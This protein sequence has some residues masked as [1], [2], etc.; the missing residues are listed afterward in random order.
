MLFRSLMTILVIGACTTVFGDQ[1][2]AK[3]DGPT[4]NA[5]LVD[6]VTTES[7]AK[8]LLGDPGKTEF[9]DNGDIQWDYDMESMN[10]GQQMEMAIGKTDRTKKTVTLLFDKRGILKHHSLTGFQ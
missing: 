9:H 10:Y 7:D 5:K 2:L 3:V 6:G 4:V 8:A 1:G